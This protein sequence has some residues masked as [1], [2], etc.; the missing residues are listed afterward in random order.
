M[1][2]IEYPID[3]IIT[4]V[5]GNDPEW[6]LEK[7]KYKGT[8][9]D[10]RANRYREWDT[11]KYWFRGVE[12]FAPWVNKIFFVTCGHLP[13]WLNTD[14]PKLKIINHKEYIP[15]KWLPTF[16]SRPIDMNFHRIKELSS[17]FVYFNDDMFL[18]NPVEREDFFQRGLPCDAAVQDVVVPKGKDDNGDKLVAD[19]LYTAVFY[20][21]AVLNRNF[22]KKTVIKANR[23]KWFTTLYGKQMIKNILLND[24]NYF[25]GFKTVHL[26]YSYLKDT[27]REVWEKE[28][29]ILSQACEHKFRTATDVNHYI[30]SYWQFAKGSF[31]PRKLSI[32]SLMSISNDESKNQKI[33]NVIRNQSKKFICINDQ[34]S[35]TNFDE[36]KEALIL[37]F[38]I[39]LPMKSSFEL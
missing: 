33:Y 7:A 20:D 3:F 8:T 19:S 17:H 15:E 4:W 36:V 10:A 24:W 37:S 38:D 5:D 18:I 28:P 34:F 23:R 14:H 39:I 35:G 22:N 6:Q 13:S 21:T 27:Y 31:M 9:G 32:G 12:K 1:K 2:N 25:T 16:S 11:L 29:E 30:F 26:P